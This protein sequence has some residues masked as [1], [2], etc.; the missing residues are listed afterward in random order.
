[1]IRLSFARPWANSSAI[2]RGFGPSSRCADGAT[3][4]GIVIFD[5]EMPAQH[6]I[7]A[8]YSYRAVHVHVLSIDLRAAATAESMHQAIAGA[9]PARFRHAWLAALAT[10]RDVHAREP[11]CFRAQC[12]RAGTWP[13]ATPAME[14]ALGSLVCTHA[15]MPVQC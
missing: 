5:T 11:T 1:M 3:P 12:G 9:D 4:D 2:D 10:W 13:M 7:S 6:I 8:L 14:A 15:S